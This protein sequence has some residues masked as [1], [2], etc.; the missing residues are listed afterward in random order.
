MIVLPKCFGGVH[1][2]MRGCVNLLTT[3]GT[4]PA[5]RTLT[6]QYILVEENT[7]YNVIKHSINLV[8]FFL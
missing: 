1:S 3:F 4:G 6:V 8:L 5:Y 2:T 7:P